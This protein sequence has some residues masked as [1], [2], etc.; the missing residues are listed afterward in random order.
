MNLYVN[1][2]ASF[3]NGY[4]AV[5]GITSET[6][7]DVGKEAGKKFLGALLKFG[8]KRI[9]SNITGGLVGGGGFTTF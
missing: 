1:L 8:F 9:I 5:D 7:E 4:Y 2:D 3:R 6:L